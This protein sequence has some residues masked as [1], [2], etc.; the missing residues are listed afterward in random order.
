MIKEQFSLSTDDFDSGRYTKVARIIVKNWPRPEPITLSKAQEVLAITLGY[1]GYHDAQKSSTPTCPAAPVIR[2]I[3]LE[4]RLDQILHLGWEACADALEAWPLH[5]LGRW[6]MAG[7]P[8]VFGSKA[9]NQAIEIFIELFGSDETVVDCF[10]VKRTPCALSLLATELSS[11]SYAELQKP[12]GSLISGVARQAVLDRAVE[13]L[14]DELLTSAFSEFL[15]AS[16]GMSPRDIWKLPRNKSSFPDLYAALNSL[17]DSWLQ[18][19]AL[20]RFLKARLPSGFYNDDPYPDRGREAKPSIIAFPTHRV[21]LHLH[22]IWLDESPFKAYSWKAR[23]LSH[24]GLALAEAEGGLVIGPKGEASSMD[25]IEA[26]EECGV[27]GVY[28]YLNRAI[29]DWKISGE[30]VAGLTPSNLNT[31]M[32]FESG[33]LL[34][35]NYLERNEQAAAGVGVG[36][37]AAVLKDLKRRY[38]RDLMVCGVV[39]AY[40]YHR[41]ARQI[42]CLEERRAADVENLSMSFLDLYYTGAVVELHFELETDTRLPCEYYYE[43]VTSSFELDD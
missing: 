32:I 10:Q 13:F 28:A 17:Y 14:F 7:R 33:N 21:E 29:A 35:I 15:C 39:D 25:L 23:S 37:I 4:Q 3:G 18:E 40:Q 19:P 42:R 38:K 27:A 43:A 16:S 22:R 31:A 30:D 34:V 12:L 20:N 8:C 24:E 1:A 36:L 2:P 11:C 9:L 26:T 41:A 5:M 6:N